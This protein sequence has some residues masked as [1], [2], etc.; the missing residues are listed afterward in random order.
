MKMRLNEC[1]ESDAMPS[2][3]VAQRYREAIYDD[4]QEVS[5][6]LLHYRGDEDELTLNLDDDPYF[7]SVLVD[8]MV[9]CKPKA[10]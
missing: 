6:A 1:Y 7:A 3:E 9:A 2:S 4:D 5:L 10:G 8:A